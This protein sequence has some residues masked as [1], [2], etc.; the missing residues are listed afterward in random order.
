MKKFF[1]AFVLASLASVSFGNPSPE[2]L[3]NKADFSKTELFESNAVFADKA[4]NAALLRDYEANTAAYK[5][6]QL[7]P[8]AVCYLSFGDIQ[9]SKAAFESFLKTSPKNIRALRT[10][11][12]ISL[13]SKDFDTAMRY[14]K[15]A[16]AAGDEKSNVFLG[17]AYI[18]ANKSD[19]VKPLLPVLEKLAKTNL[20]ALNV[21]M[22]YA[23]RDRKNFDKEL[24]QK[25]LSGVD[26]RSVLESA[27]P[28]GMS[29][30]LRLYL[31]TR[32]MWP[33]SA[34]AVPAR[35]AA[36]AELWT[37]AL[38]AYKKIL[39]AEP[40]NRLAL[41]GMGLVAFRTGDIMGAA[42]YI[43]KAY[44]AGEK[45]AVSDGI[46]LFLLSRNRAVWEIFK[47][48]AGE[49]DPAPAVLAE[50]VRFSVG[51]DDSAD[52]F[53][54]GALGKN[55]EPLYADEAVSKLLE[56]GVKKYSSDKR[57]AEVA[58]RLAAAKPAKK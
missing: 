28:D 36:L 6:D 7:L 34:L 52:A 37:V 38:P 35:A 49:V 55:S 12:T 13:I 8:I 5:P 23:G 45:A 20:E 48:L 1:T 44:K 47:P 31:A 26:A 11:G 33:V 3:K 51:R 27:T 4:A 53:Y 29:T 25:V 19:E 43:M 16:I 57:S 58:K 50:L 22:F 2:L 18:M 21:V 32:D 56:D 54:Y 24:V 14:Y 15:T 9:K 41:R 46:D 17:S 30:V 10:L 42:D 39:A 40:N